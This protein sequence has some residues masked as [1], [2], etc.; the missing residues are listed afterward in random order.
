M[1]IIWVRSLINVHKTCS[2]VLKP[3]NTKPVMHCGLMLKGQHLTLPRSLLLLKP[4]AFHWSF[5]ASSPWESLRLDFLKLLMLV[6]ESSLY[7]YELHQATLT[8]FSKYIFLQLTIFTSFNIEVL[9]FLGGS[10]VA[11]LHA[12]LTPHP[13]YLSVFSFSW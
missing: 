8:N 5:S 6:T 3:W 9:T 13:A 1:F 10:V 4:T 2:R 7:H 12:N 11:Y